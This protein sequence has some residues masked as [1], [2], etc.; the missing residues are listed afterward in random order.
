MPRHWSDSHLWSFDLETT[1]LDP[2]RDRILSAALV[3]VSPDGEAVLPSYSCIVDPGV[4]VPEEASRVNGLTTERVQREGITPAA[5]LRYIVSLLMRCKSEGT[6]LVIMNAPF[7]WP[8]LMAECARHGIQE[9]P[10][11]PIFNPLL[12]DRHTNPY[13]KGSRRLEA[14]CYRYGVTLTDAH[15]AGADAVAAAHVSRVIAKANP[16]LLER[17]PRQLHIEQI[18]WYAEWR[19]EINRYWERR[20]ETRRVTGSWPDGDLH[21]EAGD[22][23]AQRVG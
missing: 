9:P 16:L 17:T 22:P 10:Q 3:Y 8:F 13:R 23:E 21:T 6:P 12:V 15:E 4:P 11:V 20:G 14:L 5:A 1:G 2:R 7:D 19:D 18:G